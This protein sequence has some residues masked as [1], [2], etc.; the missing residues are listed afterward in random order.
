MNDTIAF[1]KIYQCSTCTKFDHKSETF[2]PVGS[3]YSFPAGKFDEDE[4]IGSSEDIYTYRKSG[5]SKKASI[6]KDASN[7]NFAF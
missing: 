2:C 7:Y 1:R 5:S 6:T 3:T 4:H